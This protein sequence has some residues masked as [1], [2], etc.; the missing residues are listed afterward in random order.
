MSQASDLQATLLPSYVATVKIT[1]HHK[2]G[3][4]APPHSNLSSSPLLALTLSSLSYF[5]AFPLSLSFPFLSSW[6]WPV[7][8]SLST[9]SLFSLPFYNEALKP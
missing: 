4:L 9:F 3:C 7:S 2:R 5:L 6:A 8:L 1:A